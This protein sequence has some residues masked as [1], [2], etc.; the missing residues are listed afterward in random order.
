MM[1]QLFRL[2]GAL[3]QWMTTLGHMILVSIFWIIGC[4]PIITIGTSTTALYYATVKSIK[5]GRSYVWTEFWQAYKRNFVKGSVITSIV[6]LLGSLFYINRNIFLETRDP[7]QGR[8]LLLF[9]VCL[10]LL[11]A[12]LVYL[13]PVM[14]RFQMKLSAMLGLSFVMSLKYLPFT[15]LLLMSTLLVAWAQI[16][17]LPWPLIFVVPA[18]LCY[19]NSYLIEKVLKAYTPKP[20]DSEDAW[21]Y[22]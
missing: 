20:A 17:V 21:Y 4:L 16:M 11:A 15:V 1:K 14:S 5:K 18:G 8:M 12:V 9:G 19:V 2:D 3:L 13:F 6:V 22:E 7:G 10:V